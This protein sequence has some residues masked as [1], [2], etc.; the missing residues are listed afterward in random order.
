MKKLLTTLFTLSILV[1]SLAFSLAQNVWTAH[2]DIGKKDW[3]SMIVSADGSKIVALTNDNF[4]YVSL[5]SGNTWAIE[6]L[7]MNNPLQVFFSDNETK[8][9]LTT[10]GDYIYS[11]SD[12][13][14]SWTPFTDLG[15]TNWSSIISSTDGTKL[16]AIKYGKSYV[17]ENSGESWT[18]HSIPEVS[19]YFITSSSDG[20]KLAA[21]APGNSQ[22]IYT[23]SDS[24]ATWTAQTGSPKILWGFIASSANGERLLASGGSKVYISTDSGITWNTTSLPEKE[25]GKV[26]SSA[27]GK[28]LAALDKTYNGN[29]IYTSSDFGET[30]TA[31]IVSKQ[32]K[33]ASIILPANNELNLIGYGDANYLNGYIYTFGSLPSPTVLSNPSNITSATSIE[34]NGYVN[35]SHTKRGVQYC[36]TGVSQ[37]PCDFNNPSSYTEVLEEGNYTLGDFKITVNNLEPNQFLHYRFFAENEQGVSYSEIKSVIFTYQEWREMGSFRE[38]VSWYSFNVSNDGKD[39]IGTGL[40]HEEGIVKVYSSKDSG[41]SWTNPI[42]DPG[43]QFQSL[44]AASSK[45]GKNLAI[46]NQNGYIYVSTN[47]G[48]SWT[49]IESLGQRA[50]LKVFLSGDGSTLLAMETSYGK[51]IFQISKDMGGTWSESE[52]ISTSGWVAGIASSFDGSKLFFSIKGAEDYIYASTDFGATWAPLT[53]AG[54][55][56]FSHIVSSEDGQKLAVLASDMNIYTSSDSGET[57]EVA[58]PLTGDD[59]YLVS[60]SSSADGE[61]LVVGGG[62]NVF[63]STNGG[64]SWKKQSGLPGDSENPSAWGNTYISPSGETIYALSH[65]G[66]GLWTYYNSLPEAQNIKIIIR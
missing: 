7:S 3:R 5:D 37:V 51:K 34:F 58:A 61:K 6:T 18:E 36:L 8:L 32:I 42:I 4:L 38:M 48:E 55:K 10:Y 31:D 30:W 14:K 54:K 21:I 56:D 16:T 53:G 20:S 41:A 11:S 24:G 33:W 26:T 63:I 65:M 25:W 12:L 27:D 28:Y 29:A 22:H 39:I 1:S 9:L 17:S 2:I 52:N 43:V 46:V 60:L 13:G 57:W 62:S 35:T 47:S 15:K 23:S 64:K 45:D 19:F 40:S 50:W 49:K 59:E 44:Y 66:Y